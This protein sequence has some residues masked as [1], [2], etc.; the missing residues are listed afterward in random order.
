MANEKRS[1]VSIG[2]SAM[3]GF[4]WSEYQMQKQTVKTELFS[5]ATTATLVA[6]LGIF[7]GACPP[8]TV[9]RNGKSVSIDQASQSDF[10]Q[11]LK[12]RR[13]GKTK[14]AITAFQKYIQDFPRSDQ[15]DDALAVIG[16]MNFE[17]KEYQA[18]VESFQQLID[19]HPQS[20]HYL[21]SA[22]HLGLSLAKL[23]RKNQALPTLQSVFDRVDNRQRKSEVAAIIADSYDQQ[24]APVEALRWY[25]IRYNLI[26]DSD[27]KAELHQRIH[28]I[29]SHRLSFIQTREALEIMPQSKTH[30]FPSGLLHYRL[31]KIFFHILDFQRARFALESFVATW[32]DHELAPEAGKLLKKIIDRNRVNPTAV[33]VLLPLTGRFRS[34][35]KIALAGIQLGAGIFDGSRTQGPTLIIRDTAGDPGQAAKHMEDLVYNE[36]VSVIIGPVLA[37]EAYT[38]AIKAQ[39]LEVPIITLTWREDITSIGKYVFRNFLTMAAQAKLLVGYAMENLGVKR[40]ALLFPN[41]KY[42]A[43][44]ANAFW[45]QI[46]KRKGEV[47]ALQRYEP[48]EKN[49]ATHIK[50]MVGRYHLG[51]RQDFTQAR[52]EIN[53]KFRNNPLGRQRA[54]ER[55]VKT[56]RPHVDFEAIFVPDYPIKVAMIAPALAFE[57][58]VIQ[59]KNT[60]KIDRMKKSLGRDDLDMVYLLGGNGWN[61]N[62]VIEW[63]KRYVQG[64]LFCDGF[65]V[66]SNR[67]AT[68]RFVEQY[69]K[70]FDNQPD[71]VVSHAFDTA[72]MVRS[73]IERNPPKSRAAFRQALLDIKDFDGAT[74]KTSFTEN[75]E[76]KKELFLLSIKDDEIIEIERGPA[77]YAG[78]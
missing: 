24:N 71:W 31:A 27:I 22:I 12:L 67:P 11:A 60:W 54:L 17:A 4:Y 1:A 65:F 35:G 78:S 66:H 2:F 73:I 49:F 10:Q 7:L 51:S 58:I 6:F 5:R 59:T 37:A 64:A 57:D 70:H 69:R 53:K 75:G 19:E 50:K 43:G 72:K 23:G 9:L 55:L 74:G 46:K 8:T 52:R 3:G 32:P 63:A 29:I 28:D 26:S 34:Y 44:F 77:I 13:A 61:N 20:P 18:A 21:R 76:T 40:F 42:G 68:R 62:K 15:V 25:A 39:E 41:D 47:R 38:A 14:Q 33:G 30:D 36:H 48:D 56:I 16:K 45:D